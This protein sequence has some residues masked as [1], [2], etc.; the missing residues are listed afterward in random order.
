MNGIRVIIVEDEFVV[1]EDI[2]ELMT[3]AGYEVTA[4]FDKAENAL[5]AI[6]DT[7]PDLVLIDVRLAGKMD[8]I[9]LAERVLESV[10]I[11]LIYITANSDSVT[12]ERAKSTRPHAFLIKPFSASN[13]LASVDLALFHF[14]NNVVP[15]RIERPEAVVD[16]PVPFSIHHSLFIRSNARYRKVKFEEIL[17]VEASGSYVHLQT[18]TDRFILSQNLSKFQQNAAVPGLVRIHRSF[19]V[20]IVHIDSFEESHVYVKNHK[21]PLS[22]NYRAEFLT[23]VRLL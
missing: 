15:D 22:E 2:T 6:R 20:N 12:Y 13:L 7:C 16:E 9:Q 3:R 4:S 19:V 23:Q 14:A 18:T 17:F 11:P 21:L 10:R 8:G 1:R 5:P